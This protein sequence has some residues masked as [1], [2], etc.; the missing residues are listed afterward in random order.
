[1]AMLAGG[2]RGRRLQLGGAGG[3][4]RGKQEANHA[5]ATQA[6]KR[7]EKGKRGRIHLPRLRGK[8]KGTNE[9]GLSRRSVGRPGGKGGGKSSMGSSLTSRGEERG[10][11]PVLKPT[12][13]RGKKGGEGEDRQER[14]ERTRYLPTPS[15]KEGGKKGWHCHIF[16]PITLDGSTE[17]EKHLGGEKEDQSA[18]NQTLFLRGKRNNFF[19]GDFLRTQFLEAKIAGGERGVFGVFS[20]YLFQERGKEEVRFS[21]SVFFIF[22]CRK[23]GL[24]HRER[25]KISAWAIFFAW[26]GRGGREKRAHSCSAERARHRKQDSGE[27]E[28]KRGLS[29]L[30]LFAGSGGGEGGGE[31]G[32]SSSL[33]TSYHIGNRGGGSTSRSRKGEKGGKKLCSP[34][35]TI[36]N[37]SHG[38]EGGG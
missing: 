19:L 14:S 35:N 27:K 31:K 29:R 25:K 28:G 26:W 18:F 32:N 36:I 34:R 6:Q 33:L 24:C 9:P 17:K 8:N 37:W 3:D 30:N 38:R 11:V 22:G 7:G 4:G 10:A 13:V 15:R 20:A 2:A 5:L 16:Y 1:V 21:L 23:E 12:D